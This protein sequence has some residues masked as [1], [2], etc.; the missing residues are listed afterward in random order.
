[1]YPAQRFSWSAVGLTL[2]VLLALTGSGAP[3][4]PLDQDRA[5]SA[6]ELYVPDEVLVVFSPQYS[7]RETDIRVS[8][9]EFGLPALDS[10]LSEYGCNLITKVI[11]FAR[12]HHAG[13]GEWLERMYV[14]RYQSDLDPAT[15]AAE[16]ETL[17]QFESVS[18]NH[19]VEF[20]YYGTSRFEPS[21]TTEFGNQWNLD[22]P[23]DSID[24]D[25]PEA[26]AITEGDPDLIIG[27]IDSGT[28]LDTTQTPWK[29][30]SDFN[31]VWID[32]EDSLSSGELS[33][34]DIDLDDD[35]GDGIE[36]NIIG[37]NWSKP[38]KWAPPNEV[39]LWSAI[40]NNYLITTATGS[41]DI[42]KLHLHG[43]FVSSIAAAALGG[44]NAVGIAHNS[45]IYVGRNDAAT[46]S[47]GD[48]EPPRV[49]RRLRYITPAA[50]AGVSSCC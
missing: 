26:W 49:L 29:L 42:Y 9:R 19:L 4:R 36:D 5:P 24:I 8:V 25:A 43:L 33:W 45:K 28:M 17:P 7:P 18:V 14:I 10:L 44:Q 47:A 23:R 39:G 27:I 31:F 46:I 15:L 48:S 1:M 20:T 12:E 38:T 30:H 50:L 32:A 6:S 22:S 37:S 13:P 16:L 41:W 3:N 35:N 11:P 21:D 2:L 40:P 34:D